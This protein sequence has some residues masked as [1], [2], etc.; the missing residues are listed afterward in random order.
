MK[1]FPH[2][3]GIVSKAMLI[4]PMAFFLPILAY[5]AVL[6]L[7]YTSSI[8]DMETTVYLADSILPHLL[9]LLAV[10][11][12]LW[13]LSKSRRAFPSPQ[14]LL[15]IVCI[16]IGAVCGAGV[17]VL[18]IGPLHDQAEVLGCARNFV[19]GN[20]SD[21]E[22]GGYLSLYPHQLGLVYYFCLCNLLAGSGDYMLIQYFN[23]V[24]L[25][26]CLCCIYKFTDLQFQSKRVSSLAI[27]LTA[28]FIP[29]L[30]YVVFVYGNLIG[31]MFSL[32]AVVYECRYLKERKIRYGAAAAVCIALGVLL[33]NNYLIVLI[34]MVIYFLADAAIEKK[35]VSLAVAAGAIACYFL[36]SQC[37]LGVTAMWSG[38]ET[39]KGVPKAAFVAMGLQ[40]GPYAPGWYN[41]YNL[42]VFMESGYDTDA[43]AQ[44][45]RED[46]GRSLREFGSDPGRA[47]Q[48]FYKKT[49]SMW[50]NPTYQSFWVVTTRT[51]ELGTQPLLQSVFE[52]RIKDALTSYM[53]LYQSLVFTGAFCGV[54]LRL[55]KIQRGQLMFATIFIG[56]FLFHLVWEAKSQYAVTYFVFLIPYAAA[57]LHT[58]SDAVCGRIA[59]RRKK[60]PPKKGK[61]RAANT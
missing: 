44:I 18:R 28:G 37:V 41:F 2:A 54:A 25:L 35:L 59:A 3:A 51:N 38:M 32:L 4:I 52:G 13:F 48:F 7:L 56:M 43:A 5:L 16:V 46:I 19:Q 11:L 8:I 58:L 12:V 6:S 10:C 36:I 49:A 14:K 33:R 47:V 30:I 45:A 15:L 27:L 22:P 60:A 31:L 24:A 53:N 40:E 9:C 1:R 50:N 34:A 21:L 61:K 26:V 23:V 17:A 39:G 29:L 20:F 42:S 55:R 57:G